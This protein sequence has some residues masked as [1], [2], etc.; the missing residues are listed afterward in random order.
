M[1]EETKEATATPFS[2]ENRR[3]KSLG[4]KMGTEE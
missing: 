1:F 4:R 2:G 3:G